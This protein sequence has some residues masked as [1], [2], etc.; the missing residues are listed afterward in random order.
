ML[1]S[2]SF[3]QL[4]QNM[5]RSDFDVDSATERSTEQERPRRIRMHAESMG[6]CSCNDCIFRPKDDRFFEGARYELNGQSFD[7]TAFFSELSGVPDAVLV[8]PGGDGEGAVRPLSVAVPNGVKSKLWMD[9]LAPGV[10]RCA[11]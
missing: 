1:S 5:T 6:Y 3:G 8:G 9:E 10:C 7:S 2:V 4:L 11:V